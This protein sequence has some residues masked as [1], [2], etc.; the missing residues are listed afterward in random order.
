MDTIDGHLSRFIEQITIS[1]FLHESWSMIIYSHDKYGNTLELTWIQKVVLDLSLNR[2]KFWVKRLWFLLLFEMTIEIIGHP[3]YHW[4]LSDMKKYKKK[5][6][7]HGLCQNNFTRK[8][9]RLGLKW[10]L[11]RAVYQAK[12]AKK[13]H[14]V[15]QKKNCQN[16]P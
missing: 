5:L 6:H 2:F 13:Y 14:R 9:R 11:H 15:Q 7:E 10:I 16:V 12:S 8:V 3:N 4:L 1:R